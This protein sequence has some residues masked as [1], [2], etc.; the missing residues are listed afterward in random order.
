MKY[1]TRISQLLIAAGLPL[2]VAPAVAVPTDP[3]AAATQA[4]A[5]PELIQAAAKGDLK[6]VQALLQS[7]P[8]L[9]N[10]S[11]TNGVT[12]LMAA[13]TNGHLAAVQAL[14]A[15]KADMERTSPLGETALMFAAFNGHL[16]IVNA[17]IAAG[18][19]V[20]A[21]DHEGESA[22]DKALEERN[23]KA[24]QVLRAAGAR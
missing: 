3:P 6:K 5:S 21:R 17:L 2:L 11:D 8:T 22:L 12:P 7:S 15:A 24:V 4:T 18:A 14:L 9:L 1:S 10:V 20:N 23:M 19:D 16:D 13:A